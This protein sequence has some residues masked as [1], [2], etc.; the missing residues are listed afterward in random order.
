MSSHVQVRNRI[1]QCIGR[2]TARLGSLVLKKD[3]ESAKLSKEDMMIR[4]L[5]VPDTIG[6]RPDFT[7]SATLKELDAMIGLKAVKSAIRGLM[8]LQL[9]NY[10]RE[11]RG[12]KIEQISLHRVFF[13]NPGTGKTTVAKIYGNLLKEFGFLSDGSVIQ[14]TGSDLIGDA[15][16]VSSTKTA[17]LL[18]KAKGKVLFIDEAYVLDPTR[19]G[20]SYGGNALDTLVEKIQANEGYESEMRDLFR[21]CGNAGLSR[22]FNLSEAIRFEDFSDDELKT[23]LKESV[24]RSGLMI[25]PETATDVVR[26]VARGR[27]LDGFGNAGA[28][29]TILGRAKLNK[30]KRL[31]AAAIEH[32]QT[33]VEERKPV[34]H[35]DLLLLEDFVTEELSVPKARA[36]FD[37]LCNCDHIHQFIDQLE[38]TISQLRS[39]GKSPADLVSSS[40]MIFTGPP[41]TGKSTVVRKFGAV[42]YNLEILPRDTV[43]VTTGKS[44]QAGHVGG[45][46]LMVTELMGKAKGGLLVID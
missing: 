16:G 11:V 28:V 46:P 38:A 25:R 2:Q 20:S 31:E 15:V 5:T 19:R 35:P 14:V 39:E 33:P 43:T 45:T 4:T 22:R 9:Q 32:R 37:D 24:I 6:E 21:N 13:G 30:S 27:R 8:E 3:E 26:I 10:D 29:E 7:N 36:Q 18:T 23:I 12:G 40:H 1:D 34:P 17:Q 41:G 42:L 44:M